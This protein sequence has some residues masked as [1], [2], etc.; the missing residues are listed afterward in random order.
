MAINLYQLTEPMGPK[1]QFSK[2]YDPVAMGP[3]RAV[4][5]GFS[6]WDKF[7]IKEGRDLT[8]KELTAWFA[9]APR[10]LALSSV[11]VGQFACYS[12]VRRGLAAPPICAR[13]RARVNKCCSRCP[14]PPSPSPPHT[15]FITVCRA[16]RQST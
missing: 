15:R 14:L 12:P 6:S 16:C 5:E 4:P 2:K 7:V 1:R 8:F 3:L 11:V 10:E 9:A 13:A